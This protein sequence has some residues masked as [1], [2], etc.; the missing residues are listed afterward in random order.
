MLGHGSLTPVSP[1]APAEKM[2]VGGSPEGVCDPGTEMTYGSAR[3]AVTAPTD[4]TAQ[5]P[6]GRP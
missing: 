6:L 5:F 2:N 4:H 1:E 3:V